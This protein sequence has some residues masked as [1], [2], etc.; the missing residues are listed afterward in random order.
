MWESKNTIKSPVA[1]SAPLVL[2]RIRPSLS[3]TFTTLTIAGICA[4]YF[5]KSSC[6]HGSIEA[7]SIMMISTKH[8]FGVL[9][10][11]DHT[12][13]SSVDHISSAK[14]NTTETVGS[15]DGGGYVDAWHCVDR[16]SISG[17]RTGISALLCALKA[18]FLMDAAAIAFASAFLLGGLSPR[19]SIIAIERTSA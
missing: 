13:R 2:A 14:Q 5:T 12:D 16:M 1:S 3:G 7:S 19:T 11:T 18:Y 6:N 9:S 17:R 15:S 4:M 10:S 8:S